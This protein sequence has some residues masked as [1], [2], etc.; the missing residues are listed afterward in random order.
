MNPRWERWRRAE[1]LVDLSC[2]SDTEVAEYRRWAGTTAHHNKVV[3][4]LIKIA[5]HRMESTP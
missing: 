4:D 3:S 5:T 2:V 1:P